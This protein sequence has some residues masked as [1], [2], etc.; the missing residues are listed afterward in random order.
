M[1]NEKRLIHMTR[2]EMRRKKEASEIKPFLNMERKDYMS[3]HNIIG[4]IAGTVFYL[5]VA[6]GGAALWVYVFEGRYFEKIWIPVVVFAA[7]LYIVFLYFY[8]SWYH[9]HCVRRYHNARLKISRL[10]KDWDMLAEMYAEEDAKRRPTVDM[11]L[12]FPEGSFGENE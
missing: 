7:V 1:L 10:K 5:I 4:F 2:M 12:L 9:E 8:R 11:D 3:F 6:A